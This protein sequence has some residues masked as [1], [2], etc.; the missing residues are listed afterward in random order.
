MYAFDVDIKMFYHISLGYWA[1]FSVKGISK[2]RKTIDETIKQNQFAKIYI[3]IIIIRNN[4][5]WK[6]EH[7]DTKLC[8]EQMD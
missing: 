8:I 4:S 2:L 6:I 1:K 5:Y 3:V 7:N